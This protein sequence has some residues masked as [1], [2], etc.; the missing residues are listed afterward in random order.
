MKKEADQRI[1]AIIEVYKKGYNHG[2]IDSTVKSPT[3]Y[4]EQRIKQIRR[5]LEGK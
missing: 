3:N 4:L 5:E 1:Q 2:F